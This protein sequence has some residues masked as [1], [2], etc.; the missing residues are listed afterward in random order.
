MVLMQGL[1]RL[2]KK[3]PLV[4][5][6]LWEMRLV[7]NRHAWRRQEA[8]RYVQLCDVRAACSIGAP[9]AQDSADVRSS[10]GG[11]GRRVCIAVFAQGSSFDRA[12]AT[13]AD[14]VTTDSVLG[15]IGASA[16]GAVGLQPSV[17][18]VCGFR[19]GR[20]GL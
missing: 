2:R 6:F 5:T 15:A 9:I 3:G 4:G 12:R 16:D 8:E 10:A 17:S 11:S 1:N 20:P 14:P 7:V 13:A 18:L 19:D